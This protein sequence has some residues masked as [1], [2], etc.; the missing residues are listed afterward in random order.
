MRSGEFSSFPLLQRFL[1][2]QRKNLL[3]EKDSFLRKK[4]RIVEENGNEKRTMEHLEAEKQQE[5]G[6]G[7]SP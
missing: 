4:W 6:S 1:F 2:L 5:K 7:E 3:K